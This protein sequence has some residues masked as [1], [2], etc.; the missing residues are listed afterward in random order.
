MKWH[1][2]Q[3]VKR[4][5][6]SS[7]FYQ[8]CRLCPMQHS[9]GFDNAAVLMQAGPDGK[10]EGGEWLT[11]TVFALTEEAYLSAVILALPRNQCIS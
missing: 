7:R 6:K 5:I 9:S 3:N 4:G 2:T 1:T 8:I 11:E 10:A